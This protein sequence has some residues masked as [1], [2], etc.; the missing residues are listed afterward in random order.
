MLSFERSHMFIRK[1]KNSGGTTSIMLLTSDRRPGKK[2]S[3][4]RVIKN[5]GA[6]SNENELALL[7]QKAEE[8]KFH[9]MTV[10]PKA[11]TLKIT[12]ARDIR[13][14]ASFNVGFLD[15]YGKLFDDI[16]SKINL[17]VHELKKLHDLIVMRI[18]SPASKRKTAMI[19][20]EYGIE[21]G[22]DSIYK[23]MDQLTDNAITQVKKI[24]HNY[25]TQLLKEQK[26]TVDV[27]FYDLT[28]VYFE[29]NTQD[30]L[31]DFGFSKDG[32]CQHVQIMLAVIVT[33]RGLPIDYE[34]FP[35]NCYEGHT[36]IP[37]IDK[38]KARYQIDQAVL[39][40]DAA[41]MN[42]INLSTLTEKKINYV[43]AARIKNT[44]KEIQ[45]S[46][47]D[48]NDYKRVSS[49]KDD[50]IQAKTINL[51]AGDTLVAFHSSKRARKDEY[52]REKDIERIEKYIKSTTKSQLTS[53][54]KK[55]YVTISKSCKLEINLD[56]LNHE[57]RFDGFFGIQTN[58]ER[59][60]PKELLSTYRGLWQVEQTFRIAKSNLEIRPVFHYN[61]KR[62]RAHFLM[63]YMSLALIRYVEFVLHTKNLDCTV[64]QLHL[65]LDQMRVT[66]V[67]HA[68][69]NVYTLLEDPPPK[70]API[71]Q[72]LDIKWHKKFSHQVDL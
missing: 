7:I 8:Y 4:L 29:T 32:K 9:L 45:G 66:K 21:C 33:K 1:K 41:L 67:H 59:I 55:P 6:S 48:Q 65:L 15:V 13:S 35:G 10:S 42:K 16:F 52:D 68:D 40:A 37:V 39:V 60:N 47:L 28:T 30:T 12:S 44:K 18:A 54:L 17:K 36:L 5:F 51:P 53:R 26:E 11:I 70:L 14:C 62:I 49:D 31:R 2:Y 56:K 20:R 24:I 25:T 34:E 19:S 69:N 64:E 43:I 63:C 57:K 58:L 3:N 27:M 50:L 61:T 23:L 72:A 38:I 22:V 71:Y 46:I